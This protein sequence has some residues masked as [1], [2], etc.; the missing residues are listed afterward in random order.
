MLRGEARFAAP[1]ALIVDDRRITARRIVIAAGTTAIVPPI[2]GLDR[3]PH[4]TNATIFDLP[5]R[6]E[7]L[8]IL[9][10]GP[11]G[12]EL[13]DA[14]NGL[15]SRVTV[16]EAATIASKEDPELVAG[17]RDALLARAVTL[18]EGA[19]VTAVEPGPALTLADGRRIAGSHLLVAVG[20]RA[21]PRRRSICRPATSGP[22][23]PA[24]PPI[25]ACAA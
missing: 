12:L 3:V 16:I 11:I 21:E 19:E 23:V 9:G 15:G 4:F 25:A 22:R 2:P 1:D 14:F 7:H 6:P 20:R 24:S 13:A 5:E 17:L 18:V 10:G 8:L